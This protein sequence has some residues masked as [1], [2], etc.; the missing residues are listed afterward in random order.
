MYDEFDVVPEVAV[1]TEQK[2]INV[3][4]SQYL[5][6]FETSNTLEVLF[7]FYTGE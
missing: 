2:Q 6:I 7:A 5:K 3:S 1:T 4:M